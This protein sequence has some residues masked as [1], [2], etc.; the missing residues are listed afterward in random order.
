MSRLGLSNRDVTAYI[1]KVSLSADKKLTKKI[2]IK[3][4]LAS[5]LASALN[6]GKG[7]LLRAKLTVSAK[8][9]DGQRTSE[10]KTVR[11]G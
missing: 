2:L 6:R 10:S 7:R 11:L 5:R 8:G 4:R 1:G 3:K 9:S